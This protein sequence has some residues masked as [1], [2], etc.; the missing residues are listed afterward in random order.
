VSAVKK[1]CLILAILAVFVLTAAASQINIIMKDG[2]VITGGFL[3]RDSDG[4]Y[5]KNEK[6]SAETIPFSKIKKAFNAQTGE[7][8]KAEGQEKQE[9]AVSGAAKAK[10]VVIESVPYKVVEKGEDTKKINYLKRSKPN[11]I[12]LDLD[13]GYIENAWLGDEIK[14]KYE[15]DR[16]GM[17]LGMSWGLLLRPFDWFGAGGYVNFELWSFPVELKSGSEIY[18][19]A[20]SYGAV[21]RM[22]PYSEDKGY[23]NED[24]AVFDLRL[25]MRSMGTIFGRAK[26]PEGEFDAVAPETVIIVGAH[27]DGF[28]VKAGYRFCTADVTIPGTTKKIKID[29]SG[30]FIS[31]GVIFNI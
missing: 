12:M 7:E 29:L 1:T 11:Y 16:M 14:N 6:G 28:G 10:E 30:L 26:L 23:A 15:F 13:F 9:S 20:Y 25:G 24:M 2:S 21:I 19:P 22:I 8:I 4:I 17:S 3:G 5:I 31:M 27:M 18:L